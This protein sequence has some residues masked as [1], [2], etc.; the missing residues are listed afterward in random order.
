MT[1]DARHNR[2]TE[3]CSGRSFVLRSNQ[4]VEE[5]AVHGRAKPYMVWRS[6]LCVV[7]RSCAWRGGAKPCVVCRR[8]AV[9]GRASEDWQSICVHRGGGA[10]GWEKNQ[11]FW[12]LQI[13]SKKIECLSYLGRGV[14]GIE[15][16]WE[17]VIRKRGK[18]NI[19]VPCTFNLW[20]F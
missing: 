2:V 19:L 10:M 9:R 15:S 7:K 14:L 17:G 8:E 11:M 4:S 1:D 3:L 12:G 18:L 5:R 13:E 16:E 6:K 20:R